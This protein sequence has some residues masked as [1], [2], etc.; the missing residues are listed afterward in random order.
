M[1]PAIHPCAPPLAFLARLISGA[2]VRW[3]DCRPEPLQRIYFA[4][5]TSHL[6]FI[7]LW[8]VL[9]AVLRASARPVAARD[10]W[11]RGQLRRYLASTVFRAVLI[12]RP[13]G[14]A[15]GARESAGQ[16][17][18]ALDDDHASLI[19][20]PEGTRG[21]GEQI[22]PFKSGLY[23]LCRD[24]PGLE[25]VP[26]YMENLNRILPKGEFLPVPLL[27]R[28]TFGPPLRLEP[29]ESKSDFLERAR[30]ALCALRN[31]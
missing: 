11:E 19:L 31:R 27:G 26:V 22:G 5:H 1:R 17:A 14:A 16:L 15:L 9:P 28:V 30:A 25:L 13:D 29:E 20:F 12:E 2:S 10:Y 24:K 21:D 3:V 4:N 23:H 18:R 6:D 8:A 7:V